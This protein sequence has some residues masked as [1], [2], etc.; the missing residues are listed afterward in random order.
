MKKL[1]K[2]VQLLWKTHKKILALEKNLEISNRTVNVQLKTIEDKIKTIERLE[3]EK[4]H[5]EETIDELKNKIIKNGHIVRYRI[6]KYM[7]LYDFN[8]YANG[9]KLSDEY[10]K[11]F[12]ED[13][14]LKMMNELIGKGFVKIIEYDDCTEIAIHIADDESR[15]L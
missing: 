10:F 6:Q 2:Y 4:T 8:P 11:R 12:V 14:K 1:S 7:P 9:Q 3:R 5:D 13:C 15:L